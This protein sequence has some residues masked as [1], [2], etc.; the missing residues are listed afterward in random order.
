MIKKTVRESNVPHSK[1]QIESN[2]PDARSLLL[3]QFYL[4][5]KTK[6]KTKIM[7]NGGSSDYYKLPNGAI[8]LNDLIEE[9]EMSFARGNIFKAL[10]RM[11]EKSGVDVEYDINKIILFAERL[12]KMNQKGQ[13][14]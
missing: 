5:S 8:D 14:L 3:E 13:S 6:A 10:Y 1:Q 9:K 2:V 12:R 4:P 11:G 7:S